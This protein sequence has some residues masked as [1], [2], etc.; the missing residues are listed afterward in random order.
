MRRKRH[1]LRVLYVEDSEDDVELALRQLRRSGYAPSATRVESA[2]A[3]HQAL[4]SGTWDI[5]LSDCGMPGFGAKEALALLRTT[6]LDVPVLV[7][8]GTIS[9]EYANSV[10]QAGA[11]AVL[12]KDALTELG[13]VVQREL[14]RHV[15]IDEP[16]PDFLVVEDSKAYARSLKRVISHWGSARVVHTARDAETAI[17][18]RAWA[19]IFLDVGLPDGSGL[20]VLARLRAFRPTT[21]VLVLTGDN[22]SEAINRACEL[23]A[24]FAMKP[25]STSLLEAFIRSAASLRQRLQGAAHRWREL[26]ALSEA[27]QDVLVRSALGESRSEVA[28]A[29]HSSILTVKKHC[30]RIVKKTGAHFFHEAVG[31]LVREVAG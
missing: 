24:S 1:R 9:E 15:P 18:A 25:A 29:R 11:R 19:A 7:V 31:R 14:R 6:T 2:D 21:P 26:Y 12:R 28:A 4:R 20:D 5:V 8:S 17:L 3:M 27:E 30:E 13:P 22:D 10:I 16:R 23:R